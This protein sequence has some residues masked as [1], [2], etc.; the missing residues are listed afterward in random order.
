[1]KN[2]LKSAALDFLAGVAATALFLLI[3]NSVASFSERATLYAAV[4][5]QI[6]LFFLANFW[7]GFKS[8]LR[9]WLTFLLLNWF[10]F[11]YLSV[12]IF[13]NRLNLL[14]NAFCLR[15]WHESVPCVENKRNAR[16]R[17]SRQGRQYSHQ[18]HR[19]FTGGRSDRQIDSTHRSFFD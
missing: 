11:V 18:A 19:L 10:L 3:A 15:F 8:V 2:Q 16:H 14:Q 13:F 17:H 12:T 6:V 7:R 4:V 9:P 1:M 5:S